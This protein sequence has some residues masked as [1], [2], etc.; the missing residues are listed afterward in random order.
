MADKYS[1]RSRP[2]KMAASDGPPSPT[3]RASGPSST[4]AAAATATATKRNPPQLPTAVEF[5]VLL[6]YPVI[7]TFGS[8]FAVLSPETRASPY[9]ATG[10]S[11]IQNAAPNYFARKNNIFNVVFVKRGWG[12][13]TIAF[14]VFV[15]THPGLATTSRKLKAGV[16]WALVTSWW[17]LVTQWCFGPAIIDRGFRYTGGKCVAAEEAVFQGTGDTS[18]L[19]TAVA[20]KA[21]GGRWSGGYDISGHVFILVLGSWFLLQEV[22]WVAI[23]A[24]GFRRREER[25]IL[26]NDGAVKGAGVEADNVES[27]VSERNRLGLGGKFA[28]VVVGLS[29]WML[30]MTAIYFH[31]WV[32]KLTGLLVAFMAIYPVYILP[33][34]V[35]ALRAVVGLPGI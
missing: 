13:I 9:D 31:T 22:G 29:W 34:W 8:L 14:V 10:Q 6:V 7:L 19:F 5:L 1:L 12:W 2:V 32:E 4:P 3:S 25:S 26:M 17:V 21:S 35:P 27:E 15:L 30:L 18:D 20:C 16:R 33:R 11:H 23:R 28:I 24:G